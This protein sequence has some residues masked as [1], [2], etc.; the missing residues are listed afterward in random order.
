MQSDAALHLG[1]RITRGAVL[2]CP[3]PTKY[4][5]VELSKE[6]RILKERRKAL[7]AR[8]LARPKGKNQKTYIG[9]GPHGR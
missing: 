9:G 3:A 4:I 8:T 6:S 5:S 1:T 7:E 2:V